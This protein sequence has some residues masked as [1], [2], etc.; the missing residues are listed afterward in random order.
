V[1]IVT[2]V[3]GFLFSVV[4]GN[5][6]VKHLNLWLRSYIGVGKEVARLTPI[7]GCTERAIYTLFYI[8]NQYQ[9]IAILFGIKVAQKLVTITKLDTQKAVREQTEKINVYLICNI[10]SL[11]FGLLGGFIISWLPSKLQ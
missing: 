8:M 6:A 5:I 1:I 9:F 2:W 10:V 7:L 3:L 11:I 4:V